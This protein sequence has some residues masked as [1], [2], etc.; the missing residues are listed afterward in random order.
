M[1][2]IPQ[3][4]VELRKQIPSDVQLVAV[5]KFHTPKSILEAYNTGQRIFGESRVQELCEK[6]E[7]LPKDIQWH[8]IGPLQRNKV[9]YIG[10]FITLIHSVDNEKLFREIVKQAEKNNRTVECLLEVKIAQ[11]ETKSGWGL[12]DAE[13]FV[14]QYISDQNA[15]HH[16]KIVGLM[17]MATLTQDTQQIHQ[18]FASLER[19]YTRLKTLFPNLPLKHLSMGMSQDW[20]IALEEGSNM[21]R[22]GTAIFGEREY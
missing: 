2:K 20:T 16:V 3:R 9:K 17:G 4:L 18:E 21:V 1:A 8:F 12:Q 14:T 10:P 5:S 7:A 6:Y 15:Q 11:E 22:I 19:C 13:T